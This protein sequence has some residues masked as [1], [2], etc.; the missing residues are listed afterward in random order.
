MMSDYF[1]VLGGGA[2]G[3]VAR[4]HLGRMMPPVSSGSWP[5]PT[6]TANLVGGLLMGLMAGWLL[7]RGDGE[8]WRLLL[9][10]GLL[11]GFT[12]FS[13][14][15]LELVQMIESGRIAGALGYALASTF[16]AILLLC[17]GL[18]AVRPA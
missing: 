6:L 18:W 17:V 1:L 2:V 5:W 8:Q 4:F 3:A 12:T 13:A 14:Y 16:G 15:S 10:V 7:R 9:G 11:G